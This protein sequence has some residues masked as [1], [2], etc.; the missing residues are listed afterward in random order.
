MEGNRRR[1]KRLRICNFLLLV[2]L[3]SLNPHL[4]SSTSDFFPSS[5]CSWWISIIVLILIRTRR[6]RG[7][8]SKRYL[9]QLIL[10]ERRKKSFRLAYRTEQKETRKVFFSFLRSLSFLLVRMMTMWE[11]KLIKRKKPSRVKDV[12]RVRIV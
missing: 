4:H 6:K 10:E 12:G 7:N 1:N 11:R 2:D 9:I 8:F 3:I 5:L